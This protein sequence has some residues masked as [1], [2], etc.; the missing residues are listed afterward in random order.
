MKHMFLIDVHADEQL[1]IYS[2]LTL[3]YNIKS[4]TPSYL[5]CHVIYL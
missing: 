2:L 5:P 4:F 1:L 3:Y